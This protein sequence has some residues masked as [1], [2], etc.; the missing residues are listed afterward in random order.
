M[1]VRRALLAASDSTKNDKWVYDTDAKTQICHC[2]EAFESF[3]PSLGWIQVKDSA[4]ICSN[5][6]GDVRI[7]THTDDDTYLIVLKDVTY[8]PEMR[9]NLTTKSR[10]RKA[11]FQVIL[12][13]DGTNPSRG[14]RKIVHK[15]TGQTA[16]SCI[17]NPDGLAK[18]ILSDQTANASVSKDCILWPRR[19]CHVSKETIHAF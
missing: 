13:D 4:C 10:V 11:G 14:T 2:K 16:I 7:R 1:F 8:A 9:F 17:K 5:G 19:L 12:D 6:T 15:S 3:V 18:A